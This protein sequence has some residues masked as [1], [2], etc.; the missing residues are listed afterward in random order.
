MKDFIRPIRNFLTTL[1]HSYVIKGWLLKGRLSNTA[2]E[3]SILYYG[4]EGVKN[5]LTRRLFNNECEV[6]PVTFELIHRFKERIREKHKVCDLLMLQGRAIPQG[7]LNLS[8]N[9]YLPLFLEMGVNLLGDDGPLESRKS[10][11][12]ARS[13]IAQ[14]DFNYVTSKESCDFDKF[15]FDM[16]LPNCKNRHKEA[17][18]IHD[19]HDLKKKAHEILFLHYQGEAVAGAVLEWNFSTRSAYYWHCGMKDGSESL[20]KMGARLAIDYYVMLRSREVGMH[21]LNLGGVRP[22][23]KDGVLEYKS[24]IGARFGSHVLDSGLLG[25]WVFNEKAIQAFLRE[26]PF[27]CY[28]NSGVYR[29]I[30]LNDRSQDDMQKEEIRYRKKGLAGIRIYPQF[31]NK[32]VQNATPADAFVL[33]SSALGS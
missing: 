22:F 5:D 9:F 21:S 7:I 12:G 20:M 17:A 18:W 8:A 10:L 11:R 32:G 23:L 28:E 25:L 19:Y 16:Y 13:K 31:E 6:K 33:N 30:F 24:R 1:A 26:Q 27:I 15:Y 3:I 29:A 2:E 14:Y 4:Y